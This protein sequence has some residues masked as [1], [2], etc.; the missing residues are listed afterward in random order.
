MD[1]L[2]GELTDDEDFLELVRQHER[3]RRPQTERFR[4]NNFEKWNDVDFKKKFRLAKPIVNYLIEEISGLIASK[5]N[6]NHALTP[7]DM[8][9]ITLRFLATGCFLQSVGDI[10]GVDKSTTSRVITKVT[11]AIASLSKDFIKMPMGVED[12]NSKAQGFY[13]ICRFPRC[14]GAVDCTHVKIQS[15]GGANAENYRNR[16]GFF[17]F[18]V[19]A[20]CDS[21]LKISNIVCRWPGSTHDSMIFR[22]SRVKAEFENGVYGN[23]LLLGDSGY[24][25]KPYLITPLANPTTRAE[26]LFNEAQIRTRNP[27]ERC[28]GVLKRRFPILATGIRLML[29]K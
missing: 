18:N 19:Q 10:S 23:N 8:V 21:D 24:G 7:A 3:L 13:N 14:I 6:K 5:T 2:L 22:N 27:I 1:P 17:S 12:R 16:K 20:I 9:F 26:N 4:P 25:V 15:P 11:R 28:F 29:I